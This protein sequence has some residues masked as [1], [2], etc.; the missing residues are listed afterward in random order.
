MSGGGPPATQGTSGQV[1]PAPTIFNSFQVIVGWG[2]VRHPGGDPGSSKLFLFL[3]SPSTSLRVVS[4]SNH[5]YPP[6]A[7]SAMTEW[8]L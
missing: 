7:D 2:F 6:P 1:N 4:L 3:G 5:G 8:R